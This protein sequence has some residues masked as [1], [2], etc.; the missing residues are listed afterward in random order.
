[1]EVEWEGVDWIHLAQGKGCW[2]VFVNTITKLRVPC[3]YLFILGRGAAFS[4]KHSEDFLIHCSPSCSSLSE[5]TGSINLLGI[6]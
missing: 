2:R 3:M 4:P 1:M 5:N 6:S